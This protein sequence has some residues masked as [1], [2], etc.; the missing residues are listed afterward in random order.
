MRGDA[1]DAAVLVG[2]SLR[3]VHD[4]PEAVHATLTALVKTA[5]DRTRLSRQV[6]DRLLGRVA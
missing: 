6:T 5:E 1:H 4:E 3:R 2:L